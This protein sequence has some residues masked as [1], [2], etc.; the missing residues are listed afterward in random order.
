MFIWSFNLTHFINLPKTYQKEAYVKVYFPSF[1]TRA[2]HF[3]SSCLALPFLEESRA[4]G[5]RPQFPSHMIPKSG[6]DLVHY[7]STITIF[8]VSSLSQSSTAK[9]TYTSNRTFSTRSQSWASGLEPT[10]KPSIRNFCSFVQE[11][12]QNRVLSGLWPKPSWLTTK[13][14][15]LYTILEHHSTSPL[16]LLPPSH[17]THYTKDRNKHPH[18]Y[19]KWEP[20]TTICMVTSVQLQRAPLLF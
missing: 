1:S 15:P 20:R 12:D 16:A 13:L 17:K 6:Q 9:Q 5:W 19:R 18:S 4:T 7:R 3:S 11:D 8:Y 10:I 14:I 2:G